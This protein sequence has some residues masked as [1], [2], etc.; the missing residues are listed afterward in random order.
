MMLP[1]GIS[2]R[3]AV[4]ADLEAILSL[5]P[6][7]RSLPCRQASIARPLE[8]GCC[9]VTE[10]EGELVAFGIVERAFFDHGFVP[11]LYVAA[12]LRRHGI[13][14]ELL[15]HLEGKCLTAKL[16]ASTNR[17]NLPMQKLLHKLGYA[18]SG[19]I[20]NLDDGDPELVFF[21][22]LK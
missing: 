17:S 12:P 4:T 1:M 10:L 6:E 7:A 16:F 19:I 20:E 8:N 15:Q 5:D 11:L 2:T 9:H 18:P 13:G 21:K 22:R 3:C 14:S